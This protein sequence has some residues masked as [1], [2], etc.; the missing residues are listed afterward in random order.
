VSNHLE[1][2]YTK[3]DVGSRAAATLYATRH[4]LVGSFT[5]QD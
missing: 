3:L 2:V 1:H 4:G 5:A